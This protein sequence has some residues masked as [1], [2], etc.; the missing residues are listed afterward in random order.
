MFFKTKDQKELEATIASLREEN[1]RLNRAVSIALE[2]ER[3][4]DNEHV[5]EIAVFRTERNLDAEYY[6]NLYKDL[7]NK[8]DEKV[9]RAITAVEKPLRKE[10][11]S[12]VTSQD[13]LHQERMTR[14]EKDHAE[15]IAK[16]DRNLEEDKKSYRKYLREEFNKQI[17]TLTEE[18]KNL[19]RD[20]MELCADLEAETNVNS[21]LTGTIEATNKTMEALVKALP[22]IDAK[23]TTPNAPTAMVG[24]GNKV[25]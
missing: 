20:N 3:V 22:T 11:E 25:A 7:S 2:R 17:D 8:F 1:N 10:Y 4:A 21:V 23:F 13:K 16:C 5:A 24:S 14:L 9:D 15:K 18:N 12:K 6:E 19:I